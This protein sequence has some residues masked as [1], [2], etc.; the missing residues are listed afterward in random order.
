[1]GSVIGSEELAERRRE[2]QRAKI[3]AELERQCNAQFIPR[4]TRRKL[5]LYEIFLTLSAIAVCAGAL[6]AGKILSDL[7]MN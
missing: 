4:S 5:W 1:M 6:I 3:I 2:R 7:A